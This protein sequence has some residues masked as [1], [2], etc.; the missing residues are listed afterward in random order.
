MMLS[1]F[2]QVSTAIKQEGCIHKWGEQF[3][4]AVPKLEIT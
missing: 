1:M 4:T 2:F 3:V